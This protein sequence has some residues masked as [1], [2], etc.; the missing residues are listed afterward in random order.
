MSSHITLANRLIKL[1]TSYEN[2]QISD[3]SLH[4][5]QTLGIGDAGNIYIRNRYLQRSHQLFLCSKPIYSDYYL[6]SLRSSAGLYTIFRLLAQPET[7]SPSNDDEAFISNLVWFKALMRNI[8]NQIGNNLFHELTYSIL[9]D[10]SIAMNDKDN[11][12]IIKF[13]FSKHSNV[14]NKNV[15]YNISFDLSFNFIE[16]NFDSKTYVDNYQKETLVKFKAENQLAAFYTLFSYYCHPSVHQSLDT[17]MNVAADL[18]DDN[19]H[20]YEHMV[21]MIKI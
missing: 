15:H 1:I 10:M 9:I 18:N 2:P 6:F 11:N 5:S 3:V 19:L 13:N 14:L 16:V 8:K 12:G 20:A 17:V 21:N 7:F 4:L